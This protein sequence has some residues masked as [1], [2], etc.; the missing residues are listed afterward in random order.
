MVKYNP[1]TLRYHANATAS[2]NPVLRRPPS[3]AMETDTRQTSERL[4]SVYGIYRLVLS[5]LLLFIHLAGL[6]PS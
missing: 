2:G 6:F 4:L 5:A 1:A 3:I